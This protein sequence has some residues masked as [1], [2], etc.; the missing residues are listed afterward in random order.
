MTEARR[1]IV[2]ATLTVAATC[3]YEWGNELA[4][5]YLRSCK[6]YR[7]VTPRLRNRHHRGDED[8]LAATFVEQLLNESTFGA[9]M[10]RNNISVSMVG[11]VVRIHIRQSNPATRP[12]S[13]HKRT[14]HRA[15]ILHMMQSHQRHNDVIFLG[16]NFADPLLRVTEQGI[17]AIIQAG[18]RNVAV[19]NFQHSLR[20]ITQTYVIGMGGQSQPQ[21]PSPRTD[22]EPVT[23]RRESSH[24]F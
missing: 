23:S 2:A 4:S 20:R 8:I 1:D 9:V 16:G 7:V 15:L 22:I 5:G 17:H 6:E 13:L 19:S 12:R 11:T 14:D 21:Q 3:I 18:I 24:Y 10:S